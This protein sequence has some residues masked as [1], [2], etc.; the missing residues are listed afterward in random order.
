MK[1]S[2]SI[3]T[4]NR[5]EVFKETYDNILKFLPERATLVVVDDAS[6]IPCKEATF[7]FDKN[8]GI[9]KAK[10][11]AFE[12]M[13]D[14]DFYFC[15]DDDCY[16]KVKDWHLPYINSGL[17]HAMMIFPK[18]ANGLSTNN[19]LIKSVGGL[20][21]FQHPCGCMLF[22]TRKCLDV[23]GG[24][25]EKY[26]IWG[27][28]HVDLSLRIFN[29]GL[30]PHPFIDVANSLQLFHSHDYYVTVDRSVSATVRKQHIKINTPKF[31]ASKSSKEFIPY[32]EMTGRIIT[33]YF[34]GVAD[35]QRDEKWK[36]NVRSLFPLLDSIYNHSESQVTILNDS[37]FYSVKM[38]VDDVAI[39]K[40]EWLFKPT[41]CTMNPYLQ[42]W[43]SIL[44]Y[45]KE[46][47]KDYVFCVDATDVKM[48]NNPFK[49]NLGN[50][51]W[52]GDEPGTIKNEWL[53]KHHNQA[54]FKDFFKTHANKPLLNA[55]ILGGRKLIVQSFLER[56]VWYIQNHEI[57]FS[58]MALFNFLLYTEF[59]D[60]VKHGRK[61]NTIFKAYDTINKHGSWFSH[62]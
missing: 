51:L 47:K 18:L 6:D 49:E 48:L 5:Y 23:V 33:T 4:H 43:V 55:G 24:M 8:V 39:G 25:D 12:L 15:F 1:I 52:V 40:S 38:G 10:N 7:R 2:I 34:T 20:S 35:P 42:R 59:A 36:P 17:N 26:G 50:Y 3:T 30:T 9:A 46:V 13:G 29:N 57:I 16:S 53:I 22:Y 44:E 11:K 14:A 61:V 28:D 31:N 41:E 32:K 54:L 19:K 21:Y 60:K 58:D 45:L 37:L 62:K 56:M 27:F